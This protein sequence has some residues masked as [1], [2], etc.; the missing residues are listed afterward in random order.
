MAA[1]R[2][3]QDGPYRMVEL[4][5]GAGAA[6]LRICPERGG[7]ATS[8]GSQGEELFYLDRDTFLDPAANIRGGNPVLFPI[9]GQLQDGRYTWEGK[10]YRMKN[11][12]LARTSPWEVEATGT[13]EA[14]EPFV[15][16]R[17]TSTEAM[18]E[19]Y[20]FAFELVFTYSLLDGALVIRQEYRNRSARPMPM[21]PG[22]HPY[23]ATAVKEL[24]YETDA[25][26]YLDYNDGVTKPF[27]GK[28]DIGPL[29]ESVV[30]LGAKTPAVS[31]RLPESGRKVTLEYTEHFRYVVL[32][33]ASGRDFVCVEPWMALNGEFHRGGELVMV[34]PG[35]TLHAVLTIR[36]ARE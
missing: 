21:Y 17:L 14:G 5:D 34:P 30:L 3:Y 1:I 19:S 33:T 24:D 12:G 22:F 23:F 9:C 4:A 13:G 10:E 28:L 32:W 7:I 20:P 29:P 11:H 6:W 27:E 8:F 25:A 26:R 15:R 35:E 16:L 36:S 2:T 18:L 31:F